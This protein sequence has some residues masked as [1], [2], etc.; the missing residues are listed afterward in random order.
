MLD[1]IVVGDV[2][3]D[4]FLI[5]PH[6]PTWDEGVLVD[7]SYEYP[8]G[9]GGNT[10][11]ALSVLGTRAGII[12]SAGDDHF[13]KV[14]LE[15]LKS[16]GVDTNGVIIVPGGQTYYCIMMLDNTGEKAIL[17]VP[18]DLI[19]P[20]PQMVQIKQEYLAQG[21]HAHF[22]GI[23]PE[24]MS[25]SIALAKKLGL[26]VSVDLDAGYQGLDACRPII[27]QADVVLLNLQGAQRF[28]PGKDPRQIAI[29][30]GHMGPS[31]VVVTAGRKGAVGYDGSKIVDAPA[32]KVDV[33]DTTGAG[34]IFS[35]AFVHGYI[36][37]W[38][39]QSSLEFASGAAALSTLAIGGQNAL[40]TE[41]EVLNFTKKHS[42][43]QLPM[44][45][46]I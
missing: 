24:R 32:Y 25:S 30:L 36:H 26:S 2:D 7:K 39:L 6:I 38:N 4:Q 21:R 33:K 16:K 5:I 42:S 45:T 10:A 14:A 43:D 12:A 1:V 23:N 17:V 3:T 44:N 35:A 37:G 27:M 9:K 22:I 8:G 34:D 19:Y 11:A 31:I 28:F 15:G 20:T 40:S 13:G 29:D 46:N 18:T 41:A